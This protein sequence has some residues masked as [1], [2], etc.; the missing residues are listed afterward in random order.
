MKRIVQLKLKED[1]RWMYRP[2]SKWTDEKGD[3][4]AIGTPWQH[5]DGTKGGA[6][7]QCRDR[8]SCYDGVEEVDQ[9]NNVINMKKE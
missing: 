6:V 5:A 1:G 8:F 4:F 2:V 7:R 9:D 3:H